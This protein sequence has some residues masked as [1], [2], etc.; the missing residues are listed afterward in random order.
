M[1][2]LVLVPLRDRDVGPAHER[3]PV[4]QVVQQ[5]RT[6]QFVHLSVLQPYFVRGPLHFEVADSALYVGAFDTRVL[7]VVVYFLLAL[8]DVAGREEEGVDEDEDGDGLV[9]HE[10]DDP[11]LEVVGFVV[12]GEGEGQ[13]DGDQS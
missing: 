2:V 5:H 8:G 9:E 11:L 4:H 10:E 3:D 7:L 6:V 13:H 1:G 12:Y